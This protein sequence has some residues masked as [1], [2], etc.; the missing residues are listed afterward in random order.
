MLVDGRFF[1]LLC[2]DSGDVYTDM[3][4]QVE[5]NQ[6]RIDMLEKENANLRMTLAK[7]SPQHSS[8]SSPRQE[9]VY[10]PP[11]GDVQYGINCCFALRLIIVLFSAKRFVVARARS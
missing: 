8:V 10:R 6:I 2:V 1:C 9:N 11:V 7:L 4:R 3:R 5:A